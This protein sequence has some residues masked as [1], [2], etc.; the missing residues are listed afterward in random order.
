MR[1]LVLALILA[2]G[3]MAIPPIGGNPAHADSRQGTLTR[4]MD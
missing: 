2:V 1:Y 3:L 4:S